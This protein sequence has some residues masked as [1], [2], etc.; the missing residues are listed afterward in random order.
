M[1]L[2]TLLLLETL[3]WNRRVK[4][5]WIGSLIGRPKGWDSPGEELSLIIF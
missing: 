3:L 1:R 5:N 2:G 4:N